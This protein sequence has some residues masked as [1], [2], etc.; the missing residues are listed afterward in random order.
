MTLPRT[1]G[2]AQHQPARNQPIAYGGREDVSLRAYQIRKTEK[3]LDDR[4]EL[5]AEVAQHAGKLRQH[6]QQ[7]EYQDA[8]GREQHEGGIAQRVGKPPAQQPRRVRA[9]YASTS[10]M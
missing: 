3:Q 1:C 10:R 7:E 2:P 8:A 6:E 5:R 4:I 9:R